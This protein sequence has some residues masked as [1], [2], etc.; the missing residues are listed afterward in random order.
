MAREVMTR[1]DTTDSRDRAL[2]PILIAPTDP[3][4]PVAAI[5]LEC[6]TPVRPVATGRLDVLGPGE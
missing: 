3:T 6:H 2:H 1:R 5:S 4:E